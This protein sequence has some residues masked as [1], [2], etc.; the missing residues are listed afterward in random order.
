VISC[1]ALFASLGGTGYAATQLHSSATA[2][3]SKKAAKPVTKSEVNKLIAAYVKAHHLGAVGP[4]GGAGPAGG[5]G[6]IGPQGP[7]VTPISDEV[8]GEAGFAKV[9]TLGPWTIEFSCKAGDVGV[10]RFTGPGSIDM[11]VTF[12]V[13]NKE[14][15]KVYDNNSLIGAE[16]VSAIGANGQMSLEGF[17]KSGTTIEH[18]SILMMTE[19][20]IFDECKIVGDGIPVSS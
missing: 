16:S 13:A 12:G 4:Q 17:L 10:T 11:T 15:E 1:V 14:A 18:V 6:P 8:R 5:I 7:G 3:K 2:A 20:G 19:K 9:A